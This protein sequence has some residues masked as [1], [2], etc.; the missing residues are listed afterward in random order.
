MA[1][2]STPVVRSY[3]P[4]DRDSLVELW[5]AC[6]LVRPW[7]DPGRDIER[8]LA[9]E[10]GGGLMVLDLDGSIVGSVMAG[11]DGHRGWVNYLAVDPAHRRQGFGALLMA[12]AERRLA[13]AGCPK[14]NLQVR[15]TNEA[16]AGFYRRLG[17]HVD[18]VVSMGKR[19][20]STS[21]APVE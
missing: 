21:P 9:H 7:N 19:L 11:Y 5:S 2:S 16:A 17:Y 1:T 13:E 18:E 20:G 3:E 15:A 6:D 10:A 4:S 8:K 12:E 14:V